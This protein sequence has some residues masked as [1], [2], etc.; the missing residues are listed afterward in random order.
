MLVS[1]GHHF[2]T[3]I[4]RNTRTGGNKELG[5]YPVDSPVGRRIMKTLRRTDPEQPLLFEED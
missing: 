4:G 3:L 5:F 1:G 2:Q